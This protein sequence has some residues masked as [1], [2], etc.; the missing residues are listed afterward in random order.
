M[1]SSMSFLRVSLILFAVSL[2]GCAQRQDIEVAEVAR[3]ELVRR[4]I[5]IDLHGL[6]EST[7]SRNLDGA[8]LFE[9]V[10][11]FSSISDSDLK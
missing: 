8:Y 9:N 2:V 1:E 4:N 10:G 11:F 3:K 7:K 5:S 6:K